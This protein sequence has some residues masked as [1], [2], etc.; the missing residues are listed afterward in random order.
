MRLVQIDD[1][2][3]CRFVEYIPIN[4][5][6]T[7]KQIYIS[8]EDRLLI[9]KTKCFDVVNNCVI[10]YD[11]TKKELIEKYNREIL[12]LKNLLSQSD[13][14]CLKW[15]EGEISDIEYEYTKNKRKEYRLKINQFEQELEQLK[16]TS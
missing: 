1:E 5:L 14:I 15:C 6:D 7:S 12:S 4:E 9:G 10:S 13:Y 2:L 16:R 8:D 11:N 3:H